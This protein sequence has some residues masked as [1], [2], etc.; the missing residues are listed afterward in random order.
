MKFEPIKK[1]NRS[2]EKIDIRFVKDGV[3]IL[4]ETKQNF[5]VS[6]GEIEKIK[7]KSKSAISRN[8]KKEIIL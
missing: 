1:E 8:L 6:L 4:I 3:S 5:N 2:F 7:G